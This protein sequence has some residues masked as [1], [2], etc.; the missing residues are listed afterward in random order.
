MPISSNCFKRRRHGEGDKATRSDNSTLLKRPFSCNTCK[1]FKS[2]LSNVI[3]DCDIILPPF[4]FFI[5]KLPNMYSIDGQ[6]K[7]Q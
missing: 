4:P 3:S 5:L 7:S 2:I 6:L 1:I